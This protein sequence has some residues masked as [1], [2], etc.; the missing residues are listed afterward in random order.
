M[1]QIQSL[2]LSLLLPKDSFSFIN[3]KA[4]TKFNLIFLCFLYFS[5]NDFRKQFD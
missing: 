2:G 3:F 1:K 4:S 5:E